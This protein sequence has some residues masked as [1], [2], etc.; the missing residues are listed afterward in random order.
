MDGS[1]LF[2]PEGPFENVR[3]LKGQAIDVRATEP[4]K[5]WR[6]WGWRKI[7]AK[8]GWGPQDVS[9]T[10]MALNTPPFPNPG[11]GPYNWVYEGPVF[12][13]NGATCRRRVYVV[14]RSVSKGGEAV[15]GLG[16]RSVPIT[17]SCN[18]RSPCDPAAYAADVRDRVQRYVDEP[19]L[20]ENRRVL[21]VDVSGSGKATQL[22]IA[23]TTAEGPAIV[24]WAIWDESNPFD[25][26]WAPPCEISGDISIELGEIL[27]TP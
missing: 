26:E 8:H 2:N 22:V 3:L 9:D 11:S 5:A 16:P 17:R 21:R 12:T 15:L 14:L 4:T 19:R 7:V 23:F 20:T 24:K 1:D 10:A 27:R 18:L 13:Q 6:G 25:E